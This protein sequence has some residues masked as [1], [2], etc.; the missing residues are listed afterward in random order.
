MPTLEAV[1]GY[2]K[3]PSA[4]SNRGLTAPDLLL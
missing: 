2:D 4:F 3:P 1:T